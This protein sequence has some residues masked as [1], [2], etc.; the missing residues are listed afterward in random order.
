[1]SKFGRQHTTA[2]LFLLPALAVYTIF[3]IN[4]VFQTV[5]Q[6]FF[7]WNG[8]AQSPMVF[9]GLS[10]YRQIL[11]SAP[12]ARALRNV[13]IFLLLGFLI[14]MPISLMLG[15]FITGKLKFL[16][17]FKVAFF[18]P[19]VL[20][21]TAIGIMWSFILM[22]KVGLLDTLL[23]TLGLG[24]LVQS[25]LGNMGVVPYTIPA[26]N[27]WVFVGQNMLIF[28]A[29]IVGISG[30]IYEAAEIDGAVGL[31]KLILVTVPM[32]KETFKIYAILCVTGCL[33]VFDIIYVLTSGGP[34][35]ASDV[36]ATLLYYS[37]FRYQRY[38][39]ANAIGVVILVL[40]LG[41]SLLLNRLL[42]VES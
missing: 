17:F 12:F 10:N 20:P 9:S 2:A 18:I 22:P 14:Q 30:D 37:A 35:G 4:P 40:C 41:G 21:M 5:Y 31:R 11:T 32:L 7:D 25:W 8:I 23:R 26:I 27:T 16:R 29:G 42:K 6:S 39:Y 19:V 13:G 33:K 34:N 24:S 1:M 38:G 36:P 15:L 3:L 28:A